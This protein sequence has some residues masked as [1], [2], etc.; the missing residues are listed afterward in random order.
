M[1]GT[2]I[3]LP[4]AHAPRGT[5]RRVR[6]EV[7][8]LSVE[9]RVVPADDGGPADVARRV[10]ERCVRASLVVAGRAGA[11][12]CLAGTSAHPVVEAC[13]RGEGAAFDAVRVA[14]AVARA[15]ADAQ[16]VDERE[17]VASM[18]IGAGV[19]SATEAGVR[20]TAGSP[21]RIAGRLRERA[22][23]GDIL[24]GGTA[25]AELVD[26][27]GAEIRDQEDTPGGSV[28]V[29]RIATVSDTHD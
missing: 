17:L 8:V 3:P 21:G 14:V 7:A 6:E 16:R 23:P 18:G 19:A 9:V 2:V 11:V 10:H 22:L 25:W 28:P 12:L 20:V 1:D 24:L 4:N 5:A 29:W 13:F 27:L 15:V 26:E